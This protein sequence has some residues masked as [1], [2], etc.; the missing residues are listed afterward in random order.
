MTTFPKAPGVYIDEVD[1]LSF[2]ISS[3]T[4]AVPVFDVSTPES[5]YRV[6][7]GDDTD[8]GILRVRV[9][10]AALRPVEFIYLEFTQ[11]IPSAASA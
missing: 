8:N 7:L 2:S 9:G 4:T 3:A 11:D 6:E 10:L 1:G 5:A